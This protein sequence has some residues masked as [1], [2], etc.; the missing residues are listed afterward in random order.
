MNRF[1]V[2]GTLMQNGCRAGQWPHAPLKIEPAEA[3]GF[4]YNLGSYPG[5]TAGDDI[6][7]GELWH[8]A[9]EHVSAT[10]TV[11]D[12]IEGFYNRPNDLYTRAEILCTTTTGEVTALTY[13][14]AHPLSGKRRIHADADGRCRWQNS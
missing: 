6:I 11:L 2:Y 4:L 14:Y 1:F 9:P 7:A 5:L 3:P 13:Y 12:A 8:I 10:L